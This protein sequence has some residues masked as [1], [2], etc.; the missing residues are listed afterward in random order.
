MK[1]AKISTSG[2]EPEDILKSRSKMRTEKTNRPRL[3]RTSFFRKREHLLD[4]KISKDH[5]RARSRIANT[6][7]QTSP[8]KDVCTPLAKTGEEAAETDA[9]KQHQNQGRARGLQLDPSSSDRRL[10]IALHVETRRGLDSTCSDISTFD[11]TK[12]LGI[13]G[14]TVTLLHG[15]ELQAHAPSVGTSLSSY[16][17]WLQ[18]KTTRTALPPL[19]TAWEI[20]TE[21]RHLGVTALT[22]YAEEWSYLSC[23]QA[24]PNMRVPTVLTCEHVYPD[25][26]SEDPSGSSVLTTTVQFQL[27]YK[28]R[29]MDFSTITSVTERIKES[30]AGSI[31]GDRNLAS[32]R[33]YTAQ[34]NTEGKLAGGL[35]YNEAGVMVQAFMQAPGWKSYDSEVGT[36]AIQS[37]CCSEANGLKFRQQL[38]TYLQTGISS[39]S[40][41]AFEAFEPYMDTKDTSFIDFWI[42]SPQVRYSYRVEGLLSV[43]SEDFVASSQTSCTTDAPL[44][45]SPAATNNNIAGNNAGGTTLSGAAAT[46][47]AA[48]QLCLNQDTYC[49]CDANNCKWNA[50]NGCVL[51]AG[52]AISCSQCPTMIGKC[53]NAACAGLTTAC[54]CATSSICGWDS[55]TFSCR[56]GGVGVSCASCATQPQCMPPYIISTLP[57]TQGEIRLSILDISLQFS[58]TVALASTAATKAWATVRCADVTGVNQGERNVAA[59]HRMQGEYLHFDQVSLPLDA[60]PNAETRSCWLKILADS[61]FDAHGLAFP[62]VDHEFVLLDSVPPYLSNFGPRVSARIQSADDAPDDDKLDT[63]VQTHLTMVFAEPVL[64]DVMSLTSL[65]YY[66]RADHPDQAQYHTKL[67]H[68]EIRRQGTHTIKIELVTVLNTIL[69]EIPY[70]LHIPAALITDL[71]GNTFGGIPCNDALSVVSTCYGAPTEW[72][73]MMKRREYAA[74]ATA[75]AASEAAITTDEIIL[76][77]GLAAVIILFLVILYCLARHYRRHLERNEYQVNPTIH[78]SSSKYL[79]EER[80]RSYLDPDMPG[81]GVWKNL[82]TKVAPSDAYLQPPSTDPSFRSGSPA[83]S[84][85]GS[86]NPGGTPSGQRGAGGMFFEAN[87]NFPSGVGGTP[88]G[89]RQGSKVSNGSGPSGGPAGGGTSQRVPGAGGDPANNGPRQ[90]EAE[91]E[92][93]TKLNWR[94]AAR[95]ARAFERSFILGGGGDK[96]LH[97]RASA[98][99]EGAARDARGRGGNK[100]SGVSSSEDDTGRGRRSGGFFRSSA[101][102]SGNAGAGAGA[103]TSPRKQPNSGS[104]QQQQQQSDAAGDQQQRASSNHAGGEH[105]RGQGS[106]RNSGAA[107][108]AGAQAGSAPSGHQ[109]PSGSRHRRASTGDVSQGGGAQSGPSSKQQSTPAGGGSKTNNGAGQQRQGGSGQQQPNAGGQQKQQKQRRASTGNA[110]GPGPSAGGAKN[111]APPNPTFKIPQH[112]DDP[113]TAKHTKEVESILK[114]HAGKNAEE[115]KKVLRDLQLKYHPD[116]NEEKFAKTVFQ[117]VQGS[118]PWFLQDI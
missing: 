97:R 89:A 4:E 17:N 12:L 26:T 51:S 29:E 88:A 49:G 1:Q 34:A 67:P 94:A 53:P 65:P 5:P 11:W 90:A 70:V 66:R 24:L 86:S 76:I 60:V 14:H 96:R 117:F 33:M 59:T 57:A 28:T 7:K 116:K 47:T 32:T 80:R 6:F 110:A 106:K 38:F 99:G 9:R 69:W 85:V 19:H 46:P 75:E 93:R 112:P 8:T 2:A 73:F 63:E 77:A 16:Q 79:A 84:G 62:G 113:N 55:T 78:F 25:T 3:R 18:L 23:N 61:L 39:G 104:A 22:E 40:N 87:F 115:K 42:T 92:E 43:C 35:N 13:V 83:G 95:A 109:Q 58:E 81:N 107:G 54:L 41:N 31:F 45:G 74:P 48:E 111:E 82:P 10:V 114:A 56:T 68:A 98:P 15:P 72:H 100:S 20:N 101:P 91:G 108:G 44:E 37:F 118:K 71:A 103:P 50:L 27:S 102:G 64:V 21:K 30:L 36:S 105:Q 52:T